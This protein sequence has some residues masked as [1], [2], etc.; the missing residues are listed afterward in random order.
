[1]AETIYSKYQNV[2]DYASATLNTKNIQFLSGTQANLNKY[3]LGSG[4][5]KEGTAKEG[6]LYLTV[7][8]HRLYIGRTIVVSGQQKTIPVPVNEGILSI[9]NLASLNSV[10]AHPGEFYYLTDDNIL[11][12]Y[13]GSAKGWVQINPDTNLDTQTSG[14]KILYSNTVDGTYV[15]ANTFNAQ[16]T[17]YTYNGTSFDIVATSA[18]GS[19]NSYY[20]KT[21]NGGKSIV[22]SLTL[23]QKDRN[24]I[25]NQESAVADIVTY[26]V[27]N[28]SSL[29]ATQQTG[30]IRSDE[31]NGEVT[32]SLSGGVADTNKT[33]VLD[34]DDGVSLDTSSTNKITIK[35]TDYA[36]V[37]GSETTTSS[38]I[39]LQ[40]NNVD[41][42]TINLATG[43]NLAFDTTSASST[44][45]LD[46]TTPTAA[47]QG[48]QLSPDEEAV[49]GK[50]YYSDS[51]GT[52]P[53]AFVAGESYEKVT[54]YGDN[55]TTPDDGDVI[56]IPK[57]SRD[58]N[59][60][61]SSI[62]DVGVKL[63][64][65]ENIASVTANNAGQI[66]IGKNQGSVTSGA[67]LYYDFNLDGQSVHALNQASLGNFYSAEKIDA[68]IQNYMKGLNALTY[69]GTVGAQ[70]STVGEDLPTTGVGVGDTYL[71]DSGVSTLDYEGNSTP[72]SVNPGDLLIANGDE[73]ALTDD[74][75][76]DPLKVYYT[77]SGGVYTKVASPT[78]ANLGSY[79][80]NTGVIQGTITWTRI[81]AGDIDTQ[82]NLSFSANNTINLQEGNSTKAY[83]KLTGGNLIQIG[84][85]TVGTTNKEY[86]F[87]HAESNLIANSDTSV[88]IGAASSGDPD[89]SAVTLNA[90]GTFS[91]PSIEVDR[92]GH[93]IAGG[94]KVYT[95]PESRNDVYSL[96]SYT[97]SGA[98]ISYDTTLRLMKN[99]AVDSSTALVGDSTGGISVT[100]GHDSNNQPVIN[101]N[102]TTHTI[103]ESSDTSTLADGGANS[104]NTF[105]AITGL[106]KDTYGHLSSITTTTFTMP[107]YTLGQTITSDTG[108]TAFNLLLS[109]GNATISSIK[110]ETSTLDFNSRSNNGQTVY[111]VNMMWH[112]F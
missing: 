55:D 52:T 86:T 10:A 54:Y 65:S 80:E 40:A 50:T 34:G 1:M 73:Y 106:T 89:T 62:A 59:G 109:S 77:Y 46:H 94:T 27:I 93:I 38:S 92:Y 83:F 19:I 108:T 16:T 5:A 21:D 78:A 95:L 81:A 63:P 20:E 91:V 99:N 61:I 84:A 15:K 51:A 6:A 49:S 112:D 107:S 48:C 87:N 56:R 66:Q 43:G 2:Y 17:Y 97:G 7:D 96:Q 29:I 82:Y 11:C 14:I 110:Y 69:K 58:A 32:I 68:L 100:G 64:N 26:F 30:I 88:V 23:Q 90:S 72:E 44:I 42:S 70:T 104:G 24:R 25:T 47:V 18:A 39:K 31:S 105:S 9:D 4:D 71:V 98:N 111:T 3:L 41:K 57:I 45:K 35:G 8:T 28:S 102:H 60:H 53:S 75:A 67:V 101:I 79:Y 37:R 85:S 12:V 74:V 76:I 33:V 13:T 36:L 103:T 22:Y